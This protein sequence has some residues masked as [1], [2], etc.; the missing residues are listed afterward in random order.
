MR[1]HKI[2]LKKKIKKH[3]MKT[4]NCEKFS[5][6][7]ALTDRLKDSAIPYMQRLLNSEKRKNT[8]KKSY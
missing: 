4:K 5:V 8:K 3:K 7:H 1:K 2:S 6:K